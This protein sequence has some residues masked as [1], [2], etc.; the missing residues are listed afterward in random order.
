MLLMVVVE[1]VVKKI[2]KKIHK[3]RKKKTFTC[4]RPSDDTR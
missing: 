4:Y 3:K 1:E 2:Q